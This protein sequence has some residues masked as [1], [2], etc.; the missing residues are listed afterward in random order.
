VSIASFE[1]T[2]AQ[3]DLEGKDRTEALQKL[4]DQAWSF[5]QVV[6]D[7]SAN[8]GDEA[9]KAGAPVS[10]S[11]QFTAAQPDPA[12][13]KIPALATAAFRLS[14]DYPSSDV[15]EGPNGYYVLHL[16]GS[17]PSR[18]LSYDEA[19]AQ[20]IAQLQKDRAT[21]LLQTEANDV[22]NRILAG[23]KAG[24]SLS[25]AAIAAGVSAET[26]PAFSLADA[27]KVDVPDFQSIIPSAVSL[28]DGQFSDFVPTDAGGLFVYMNGHEPVP[29]SSFLTGE[30]L[31]KD[32]FTRQ[33]HEGAFEEWLRLRKEAAHLQ[34]VPQHT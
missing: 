16:A 11:A 2:D 5:A 26:I 20:I 21:Q 10:D 34:I 30:S 6:V 33:K 9:K 28:S 4:G 12:Y 15:L 24:K 17:V 19:K 1:L 22:R 13:A 18:Q 25:D 23:V 8:F 14:T 7:K 31:V 3:K 32:Q 27:S 29:A